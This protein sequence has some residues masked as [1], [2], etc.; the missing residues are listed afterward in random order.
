MKAVV[1]KET[2]P[3]TDRLQMAEVTLPEPAIDEVQIS[4]VAR[5]LNPSDEM[6]IKGVYRQKPELPQIAGLEGAGIIEKCGQAVDKNLLG[7]HV[8]FRTRN[9][10][11]EKINLKLSQVRVVPGTIPFETACQLSLNTLTAYA[12]L[13]SANLVANQWLLLT[14]ASSSVSRQ[15]IQLAKWKGINVIAVVRND[16]HRDTLLSLGA[17]VVL[18]S[19]TQPIEEEIKRF[20][21]NGA[22]AI[23]EAVGGKLGT[24]LF[25]VAAPYS[26]M[27]IYGR[28][29]NDDV[30]FSYASVIYKNM[31]LEG[32]GIDRWLSSKK[33]QDMDLIWREIISLVEAGKLQV[34]HEAV[35]ELA[36]FKEAILFYKN[37]GKRVILK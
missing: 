13:E 5:P 37:T 10:W 22:N 30:S 14:A 18:N 24:M 29:S 11:A 12:L 6:F 16:E 26:K 15:V 34:N 27:I 4:I 7:R 9:T 32:F 8:A 25:T 23:L 28:L 17:T 3:W 21:G 1:F 31:T 19:E 2:G 36:S 20:T 35:F 33:E